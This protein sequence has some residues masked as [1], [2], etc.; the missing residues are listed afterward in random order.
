MKIRP[1]RTYFWKKKILDQNYFQVRLI[2]IHFGTH[3]KTSVKEHLS[4]GAKVNPTHG[5]TSEGVAHYD[6]NNRISDS[7]VS[8][9]SKGGDNF[10]ANDNDAGGSSNNGVTTNDDGVANSEGAHTNADTAR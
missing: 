2:R 7:G 9:S 6:V 1:L 5:S 4:N 8:T 3:G 10:R